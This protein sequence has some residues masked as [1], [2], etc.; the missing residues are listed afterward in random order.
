MD[1][2]DAKNNKVD[3]KLNEDMRDGI[4][5]YVGNIKIKDLFWNE[6]TNIDENN[7]VFMYPWIAKGNKFITWFMLTQVA[8]DFK[9]KIFASPATD[10]Q[11]DKIGRNSYIVFPFLT[12][13]FVLSS[14]VDTKE[15]FT[16]TVMDISRINEYRIWR[17]LVPLNDRHLPKFVRGLDNGDF[18]FLKIFQIFLKF[19]NFYT[20]SATGG[21]FYYY[22]I[23]FI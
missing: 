7:T 13:V 1:F 6:L 2:T 3:I 9:I 17:C 21:L 5:K 22:F 23:V 8:T 16:L 15:W 14:G 12:H 10:M 19:Y 20:K 4:S 11:I 18:L